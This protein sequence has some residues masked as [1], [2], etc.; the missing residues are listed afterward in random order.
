MIRKLIMFIF[1]LLLLALTVAMLFFASAIYDTSKQESVETYFFQTNELSV[2]RPGAPVRASE[3]G[4]TAMRE[5]LI[6]KYVTEYFYA[7][8]DTENIAV[9]TIGSSTLARMSDPDVFNNW[10]NGEAESIKT[11]AEND[12]MRTVMID[13]EI[14]KP[15]DSDYWIVPYVL[16][17]WTAPNDMSAPPRIERGMLLMDVSYQPGIRKILGL[18]T[19]DVGKYLKR[20]YNKF[21]TGYDPAVIFQFKVLNLERITND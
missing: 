9:R 3:I 1:G 16:S 19:F 17:T 18:R 14:F 13:G 5:M 4:E 10:V 11:L 7:I 8:P 6:R 15:A 20:G 2:M 12:M 21:E